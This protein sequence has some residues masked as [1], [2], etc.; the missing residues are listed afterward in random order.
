MWEEYDKLSFPVS[1]EDGDLLGNL[2]RLY[3]YVRKGGSC[4]LKE[5]MSG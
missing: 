2:D 5:D 3:L 1:T 4:S